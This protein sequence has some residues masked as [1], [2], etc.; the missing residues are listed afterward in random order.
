MRLTTFVIALI[1]ATPALAAPKVLTDIAPIHGLVSEVMG[2]LGAP[3][4]LLPPNT[5]A[6]HYTMRPSDAQAVND[7]EVIIWVGDALTPWLAEPL[8]NLAPEA[9]ILPLLETSGWTP[10]QLP[11]D[12][13]GHGGIDPHA[14][15]DPAIAAVWVVR[16]SETLATADPENA[17]IYA[18][19]AQA[20]A[21][22]Y[23]ALGES[24][25]DELVPAAGKNLVW[26]HDAY[27]Y[28][29]A[30]FG[31]SGVSAI[32]QSDA[33]DPGPAHIAELR[34]MVV[35]GG[36][37][38]VLLD[39]EINARWA[40][41]LTEGTAVPVVTIDPIGAGLPQGAEFYSALMMQLAKSIAQCS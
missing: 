38:C 1:A 13:H 37:D 25:T 16:I 5:D 23:A 32:A 7:A 12:G 15:L 31:L 11:D 14:W 40:Q 28:F 8:V 10:R 3:V 2:D 27:G 6:H 17:A 19:N 35:T 39:A 24:I 29:A 36:A 4:L 18:Q 41:V 26:P 21:V 33:S 9:T 30:R 20:M 22:E 34:D